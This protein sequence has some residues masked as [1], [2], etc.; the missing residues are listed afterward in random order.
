M[1]KKIKNKKAFSLIE[2]LIVIWIITI[3]TSV[4][5]FTFTS[6]IDKL[7][8]KTNLWLLLDDFKSLDK[9]INKKEIFDYEIHLEK[10][11]LFSYSY[12]NKFDLDYKIN[13]N[14]FNE[15]TRIWSIDLIGLTS[16]TWTLKYYKKNKFIKKE[17]LW[18]DQTFELKMDDEIYYKITW[19]HGWIHLNNTNINYIS[20]S[21]LK[22]NDSNYLR[23]FWANTKHDETWVSY[24]NIIIQNILWK[25]IFYEN[26]I[27]ESN[28][29]NRNSI[30]IIFENNKLEHEYIEIKK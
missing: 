16:G 11:N 28:K 23:I 13:L 3:V 22:S 1:R 26:S 19:M 9:K 15:I 2:L 29:I 24:N 21:N 18:W 27:S 14:S 17:T 8:F 4:W 6:F 10:W 20:E 7:D 25:K 5:A 30:Y 12:E